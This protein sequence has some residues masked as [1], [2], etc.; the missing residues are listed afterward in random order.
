[1]EPVK[2]LS[3]SLLQKKLTTYSRKQFL[4]KYLPYM[5]ERVLKNTNSYF[6]DL[7]LCLSGISLGDIVGKVLPKAEGLEKI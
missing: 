4:R 2:H 3:C 6:D 7:L 1:M 5:F